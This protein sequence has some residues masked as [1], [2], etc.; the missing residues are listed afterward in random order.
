MAKRKAVPSKSKF[1]EKK[2]Q[3][4]EIEKLRQ[5]MRENDSDAAV[6]YAKRMY[7]DKHPVR[8]KKEE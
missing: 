8:K 7:V 3:E 4:R 1:I 5:R 6:E 2:I